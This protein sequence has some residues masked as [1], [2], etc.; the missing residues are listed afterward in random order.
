MQTVAAGIIDDGT[1]RDRAKAAKG[2]NFNSFFLGE[3][4]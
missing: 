4:D 3:C 1:L 2:W